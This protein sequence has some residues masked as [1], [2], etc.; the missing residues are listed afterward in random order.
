[1]PII[2][3]SRTPRLGQQHSYSL[4]PPPADDCEV[5]WKING[6]VVSLRDETGG[7]RILGIGASGVVSVEV[8]GDISDSS[9]SA[10][11][12]CSD[13][14]PLI[15]PSMA[16]GATESA[17][18][19]DTP[20]CRAAIRAYHA[21]LPAAIQAKKQLE[22]VCARVRYI[23]SLLRLVFF[24]I[25]LSLVLI[26]FCHALNWNIVFCYS[27]YVALAL[28]LIIE[29]V[30][31][32]RYINAL[33]DFLSARTACQEAAEIATFRYLDAAIE[34]CPTGCDPK[35]IEISCECD[36]WF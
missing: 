16:I 6:Q 7:L 9:I 22:A 32:A 5:I 15:I 4:S 24:Y 31:T 2:K 8:I 11:I 33:Q 10:E 30:L 17:D 1:M 34:A 14:D 3:E 13:L 25:G 21:V 20:E 19:C 23:R 27:F 36:I 18:P 26:G 35:E 28:L 29:S 12:H